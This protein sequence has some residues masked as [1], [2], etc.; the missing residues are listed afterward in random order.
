VSKSKLAPQDVGLERQA[1]KLEGGE[2]MRHV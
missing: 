2:K 1:A